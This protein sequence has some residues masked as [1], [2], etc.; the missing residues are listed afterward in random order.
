V[1]F[2]AFAFVLAFAVPS[3][4]IGPITEKSFTLSTTWMLAVIAAG[5][6]VIPLLVVSFTGAFL[7]YLL[8]LRLSYLVYAVIVVAATGYIG[9]VANSRS[10]ELA[11]V[12]VAHDDPES[13]DESMRP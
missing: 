8:I 5:L 6:G 12:R 13:R 11:S 3:L 2:Q 9:S 1:G 7:Q 10:R 4:L